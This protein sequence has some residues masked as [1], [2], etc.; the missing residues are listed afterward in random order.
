SLIF[1]LAGTGTAGTVADG[2]PAV[3]ANLQPN[4]SVAPLADGTFVVGAGDTV[5]RVD[6][7]GTLR[8][9]ARGTHVSGLAGL[10]GGGFLVAAG[11]EGGVQMVD[12]NG[13]VTT[14]AGG[15]KS[16][17]DGVPA[18]QAQLGQLSSVAVVPGGGFV[19]GDGGIGLVRRVGPDGL[20]RT[21]AGNGETESE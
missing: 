7:T 9:V 16:R 21:I 1:T 8:V 15:G 20:I 17:A 19:I 10:P 4:A 3:R 14:V 11:D 12:A 2:T 6:A 5:A 18:T 13:A